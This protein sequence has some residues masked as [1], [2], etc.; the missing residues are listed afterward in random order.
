MAKPL[1]T[2]ELENEAISYGMHYVIGLDE[3]G[4]GAV[5]G[6]IA[7]GAVLKMLPI[8][9]FPEGT[10][11]SKQLTEKRRLALNPLL[12]AWAEAHSVGYASAQEIDRLGIMPAQRIAAQRALKM[13]VEEFSDRE[14]LENLFGGM[15]VDGG[16]DWLGEIPTD[17]GLPHNMNRLVRPK[18]DQDSAT[19][20]AAAIIAKVARDEKMS[21]L[22]E[23]FPQ[24]LWHRNR[25]YGSAA[26]MLAI[27]ECGATDWHRKSWLK[28]S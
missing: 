9:S 1:P 4:R 12:Q 20:A 6:P 16:H 2:L 28:R 19:V 18:L 17:V 10:Q 23:D 27:Q 7:V 8:D 14:S 26:H 15:L 21:A 13:L 11:D 22:S 5:A 24:Y 3:V 25:G